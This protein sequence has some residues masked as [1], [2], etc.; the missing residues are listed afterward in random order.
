MSTRPGVP[1]TSFDAY[2]AVAE[3]LESL[4][5]EP[6]VMALRSCHSDSESSATGRC[7]KDAPRSL[8]SLWDEFVQPRAKHHTLLLIWIG[9]RPDEECRRVASVDRHMRDSGRY[10]IRE[11]RRGWL[12][13]PR[14]AAWS[15]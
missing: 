2:Q 1:M 8:T 12:T 4:A 6:Q 5:A 7:S 15:V 13:W 9:P 3:S 11:N 14:H 10:E